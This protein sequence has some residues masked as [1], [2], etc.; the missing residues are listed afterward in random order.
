MQNAGAF[1]LLTV[2][3]V[4]APGP[5][6]AIVTKNALQHGR[7]SAIRTSFGVVTGLLCWTL[8]S[9]VGV[10]ALL[11]ASTRV[12]DLVRLAG[13]AYLVFLGIQAIAD[14]FRRR[15]SNEPTAIAASDDDDDDD[16]AAAADRP[17]P[18]AF[19]QGLLSNLLNPKI[20][21]FFTSF[22]PQFV[23]PGAPA[24]WVTFLL[25]SMFA[26]IG[27]AW[28]LTYTVVATRLAAVLRRSAVRRW[29]ERVTGVV[30]IA[31]GVR[32]ALERR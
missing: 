1:L 23:A 17:A 14:S 16:D 3:I 24:F 9:A 31:F 12:F 15:H 11:R 32:L 4:L 27:L 22:L 13:A 10:A 29:V 8:A 6:T 21:V 18:P 2:L 20:G 7:A 30:L 19:R 26:A 25:G 5:D 28:L